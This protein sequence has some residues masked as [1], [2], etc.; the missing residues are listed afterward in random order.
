MATRVRSDRL[1]FETSIETRAALSRQPA[2]DGAHR[3]GRAGR[4]RRSSAATRS[5]TR[6]AFT[7]TA[8]SRTAA[9]TRSCGRRTS[10]CRRR[11]WCS[12]STRA[13]T[14]CSAAASSSARL[15]IATSSTDLQ[16]RHRARG[17]RK[18]RHRRRPRGDRPAAS[19]RARRTRSLCTRRLISPTLQPK[20]DTGT[21]CRHCGVGIRDSVRA[22]NRGWRIRGTSDLGSRAIPDP[23]LLHR[24]TLR[25]IPRLID[26]AT[27]R[28]AM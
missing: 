4:T 20:P 3:R 15:S 2:A 21:G 1:P 28:T 27:A 5:R 14:P 11:R 19:A 13:A 16:G 26:V 6:P 8:C 10:A 9:P 7:R 18:S 12:A 24:H 22:R 23:D 25:Q 17:S